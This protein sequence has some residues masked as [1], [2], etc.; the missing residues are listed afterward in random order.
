MIDHECSGESLRKRQT[1]LCRPECSAADVMPIEIAPVE[2]A[3]HGLSGAFIAASLERRACCM[4]DSEQLDGKGPRRLLNSS[5]VPRSQERCAKPRLPSGAGSLL[6]TGPTSSGFAP[7]RDVLPRVHDSKVS[8]INRR[9][10]RLRRPM[11]HVKLSR[12]SMEDENANLKV[13]LPR[14]GDKI[15]SLSTPR[16]GRAIDLPV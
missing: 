13:N 1:Y 12:R 10:A 14:D 11:F 7:V 15:A 2:S 5:K 9:N 16:T 3:D 4:R 8:V 6:P